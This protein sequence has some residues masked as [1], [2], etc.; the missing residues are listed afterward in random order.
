MSSKEDVFRRQEADPKHRKKTKDGIREKRAYIYALNKIRAIKLQGKCEKVGATA[1]ETVSRWNK[2]KCGD[3]GN[4]GK[5]PLDQT[6]G[7]LSCVW[8][9]QNCGVKEMH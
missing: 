2:L 3:S 5:N 8:W 4:W 1:E 7:T 9:R 6:P